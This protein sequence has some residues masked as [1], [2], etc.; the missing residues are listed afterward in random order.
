MKTTEALSNAAK[1]HPSLKGHSNMFRRGDH[2]Y[3]S[4]EEARVILDKF[5]DQYEIS[6]QY[7]DGKI[8]KTR[9][10]IV[11]IRFYGS[12]LFGVNQARR[13]RQRPPLVGGTEDG[14]A[15][16][17]DLG[18]RIYAKI[19]DPAL[20]P[21]ERRRMPRVGLEV[22]TF[23]KNVAYSIEGHTIDNEYRRPV[24]ETID[25]FIERGERGAFEPPSDNLGDLD[26]F[27]SQEARDAQRAASEALQELDE[28]HGK[29]LR[30]QTAEYLREQGYKARIRNIVKL[31][32]SQGWK[33]QSFILPSDKKVQILTAIMK[34][35]RCTSAEA[36]TAYEAICRMARMNKR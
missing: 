24:D 26:Q 14:Q 7:A 32:L 31:I 33:G 9:R 5:L 8:R 16:L 19:T 10:Q 3:Y 34:V 35:T 21:K 18:A 22:S 11:R 1:H 36:E 20:G 29:E 6:E 25:D 30:E 12:I 2:E 13:E 27:I 17:Q 15:H 23:L 4:A 28:D